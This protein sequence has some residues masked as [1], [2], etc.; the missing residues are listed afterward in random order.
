MKLRIRGNSIRLRLTQSEV[1]QLAEDGRVENLI[2]FGNSELRYVIARIGDGQRLGADFRDN[3]I[4]IS[5]PAAT[6]SEWANS[7]RVGI[8]AAQTIDES[9]LQILI[10]K[11]FACLKPRDG[12][13][14]G[15]TFANP[16]AA[17]N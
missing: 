2:S 15:D 10:E 4:T 3:E 7:E 9:E 1:S 6:V 14:D 17:G 16:L 8:E 13:D 12:E 11:D 5:V